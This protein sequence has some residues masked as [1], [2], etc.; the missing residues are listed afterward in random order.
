MKPADCGAVSARSIMTLP[1]ILSDWL[2]GAPEG[3]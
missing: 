2:A 1:A 3:Q